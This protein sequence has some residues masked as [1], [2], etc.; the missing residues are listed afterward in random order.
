VAKKDYKK[1]LKELYTPS[2]KEVSEVIVP[3]MNYIAIDG[4]GDPNTSKE[5]VD[6]IQTLY[7]V[8]YTIKFSIKKAGG[9]DFSVMPIEGLWWSDDMNDFTAGKKDNW[10]WT[11]MMMQPDIVTKEI[12]EKAIAEVKAKK[13]PTSID[14]IRFE[15]F[16]EG[17]AGQ[18]LHIGPF[19][20]EG[21]NIQKIH[22]YIK[23]KG[24]IFDGKTQKHHE[25]YLSDPR[26]VAPEK[27]KT[28]IR[29][30]FILK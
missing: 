9:P 13:H 18:I 29:Q 6:A 10:Y 14:K 7:P 5:Y 2:A 11:S 25:I 1:E 23:S 12:F 15:S 28:V 8:A 30:S 21:P 26:R 3:K 19:S 4:K 27:L 16:D 17:R 20:A 24:G 22:N